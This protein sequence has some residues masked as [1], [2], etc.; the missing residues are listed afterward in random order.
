MRFK[1]QLNRIVNLPNTPSRIVSLVPSQTELLVD[2]GLR[3]KIVGAFYRGCRIGVIK[4]DMGDAADR[5]KRT[6]LEFGLC[7]VADH[8]HCRRTLGG[9]VTRDQR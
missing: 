8:R 9:E 3:H 7:A 5:L 2:L 1:D 4:A 6:T